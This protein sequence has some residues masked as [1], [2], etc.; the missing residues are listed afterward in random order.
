MPCVDRFFHCLT[1]EG[2]PQP[3]NTSK[4]RV[5]AFLAS[6]ERPGLLLGQAAAKGYWPW[7]SEAFEEVKDFLAQIVD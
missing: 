3:Q 1:D 7:D 5:Q 6:R 2:C 4:A